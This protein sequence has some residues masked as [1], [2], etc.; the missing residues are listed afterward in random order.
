MRVTNIRGEEFEL[1]KDEEKFLRAL[2]R[3]DKLNQGRIGLFANGSISIRMGENWHD[4][5]ID[6]LINIRCEGG[7]GGDNAYPGTRIRG[8]ILKG[9]NRSRF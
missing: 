3:L 2:K 8:I 5:E 9:N 1:T 6:S 4:D 7:D